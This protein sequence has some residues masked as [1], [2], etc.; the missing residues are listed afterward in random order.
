MSN[1]ANDSF[2][3]VVIG[4][5]PGIYLSAYAILQWACARIGA[6]LAT[7]NPA[8][9]IDEIVNNLR[10]VDARALVIVPRIRSSNYLELLRS[11]LL[12]LSAATPGNIDDPILPSLRHLIVFNN[13][14]GDE[15]RTPIADIK[16][17]MN[18]HDL[19]LYDDQSMDAVLARTTKTLD[20]DDVIN[21]QFTSGTTGAPKA[22]SLTHH[23][24][25]NN[26]WFIGRCMNLTHIDKICE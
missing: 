25:L 2:G 18:F 20:E 8:Y 22:V 9:R 23:N 10:L 4:L 13:S 15:D 16:A 11:K 26:G 12:T 14:T 5:M 19:F 21:L 1:R 6:V 3:N 24:L 7:I 17:S